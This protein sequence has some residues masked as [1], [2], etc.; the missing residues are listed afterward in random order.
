MGLN[1]DCTQQNISQNNGYHHEYTRIVAYLVLFT[2]TMC[3]YW[4]V[5]T[6]KFVS[7]DDIWYILN[8]TRVHDGLSLKS[9]IWAFTDTHAGNWHPLI[10]ISY[11]INYEFSGLEPAYLFTLAVSYASAENFEEA[12]KYCE[13]VIQLAE[14]SGQSQ[15]VAKIRPAMQNFK[16][17]LPYNPKSKLP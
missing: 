8:E 13:T 2:A 17:G 1:V 9:L 14:A 11:L 10:T 16:A 12:I 7:F 5:R 15:F 4:Y 3:L 6:H